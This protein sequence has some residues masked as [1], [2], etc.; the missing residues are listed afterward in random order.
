MKRIIA[1]FCMSVIMMTAVRAQTSWG[2]RGGLD[3][4]TYTIGVKK[5]SLSINPGRNIGFYLGG[6]YD[7]RFNDNWGVQVEATYN[8][9]GVSLGV[10]KG[11]LTDDLLG[12]MDE[13]MPAELKEN[14]QASVIMHNIRIP[15]MARYQAS[16]NLGLVAG[17][18][19]SYTAGVGV[20]L[21]NNVQT[22]IGG[23]NW[24][25]IKA[26]VID[27]LEENLNKI[28]AGLVLG[29]EYSFCKSMFVDLRY[30]FSLTNSLKL[31]EDI[32]IDL[33]PTLKYNALQIGIG[34]R[35]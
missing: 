21:N 12:Y 1:L 8:Y 33:T 9:E 19:L 15:V 14:L 4:S 6:I 5:A 29:L 18:Y 16:Q 26:E 34:Y 25:E 27:L 28:D 20:K 30:N 24:D 13:D 17:P 35:F 22:L 32:D 3:L 23:E 11:L 31:E 10:K 2:I 7:H